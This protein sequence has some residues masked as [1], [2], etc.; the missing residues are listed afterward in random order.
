M[1][2]FLLAIFYVGLHWFPPGRTSIVEIS[3]KSSTFK[4]ITG[5]LTIDGLLN[6]RTD[7]TLDALRHLVLPVFTLTLAHWATLGRITRAAI[8]SEKGKEYVT[9]AFARGLRQRSVIWRHALRNA[10]LPALTSVILSTASLLTSVFVIERIFN[11]KGLSELVTTSMT[12]TPDAPVALGFAVYS[13]LI[14][15]PLMFILD[16]TKAIIDP[17]ILA[18]ENGEVL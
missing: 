14:V 9:A 15:M 13:V 12:R 11:L 6:G 1:G 10:T 2:L 8:I 7:V 18:S 3:L 5:L 17:R 4:T 16:M